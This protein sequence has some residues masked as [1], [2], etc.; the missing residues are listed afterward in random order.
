MCSKFVEFVRNVLCCDFVA[1]WLYLHIFKQWRSGAGAGVVVIVKVA[2]A[3]EHPPDHYEK[4]EWN[5]KNWLLKDNYGF[6][7]I[8]DFHI[9]WLRAF[10][11]I[12]TL[13]FQ[14][15]TCDFSIWAPT[16]KPS[17]ETMN[18]L[19]IVSNFALTQSQIHDSTGKWALWAALSALGQWGSQMQC[20][21]RGHSPPLGTG[22]WDLKT[23]TRTHT[24]ENLG[25]LLHS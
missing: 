9:S 16:T 10:S 20:F 6:A 15:G 18:N 25:A 24:G 17:S 5:F 21:T 13:L 7:S 8:K 4:V 12:C 19:Q 14:V 3:T 22:C 1:T 23:G 2:L 11:V